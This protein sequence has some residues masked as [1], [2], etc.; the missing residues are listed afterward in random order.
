MRSE[1]TPRRQPTRRP[2]VVELFSG[3]GLFGLAFQMQG[4]RLRMA[5]E[6]DSAAAATYARNLGGGV[7]VC[8]LATQKPEGRADV[9]IAGPPCQ[10]YSSLGR[11]DPDDPRNALALVIPHWARAL[12]ARVVVVENVA[13]FLKSPI[14][15]RLQCRFSDLGYETFTWVVD[16]SDFGA[17]QRRVRSFTVFS[18]VGKPGFCAA[19]GSPST[20]VNS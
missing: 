17:P 4:F 11:R 12:K 1:F 9:I 3:A 15:D 18:K 13:Q 6:R 10:G 8:D 2:E 20:K 5:Y 19:S 14:W 7:K 16:A